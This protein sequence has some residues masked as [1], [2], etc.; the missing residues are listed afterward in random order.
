MGNA[1][2]HA[3]YGWDA[4]IRLLVDSSAAKSIASRTG[5]GKLRHLEIEFP[6]LQEAVRAKKA[7]L[8]KARGDVNPADIVTEPKSLNE[9]KGMF[10]FPSIDWCDRARANAITFSCIDGRPFWPRGCWAMDTISRAQDLWG[11]SAS[12]IQSAASRL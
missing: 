7:V 6:W 8:S 10:S 11:Q 5:L 12:S 9:M 1:V 4:K 2:P 3:R